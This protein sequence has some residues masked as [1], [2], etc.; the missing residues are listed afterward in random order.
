MGQR[1]PLKL[2][3]AS[4]APDK[5][6]KGTLAA[7]V[8]ATKLKKPKAIADNNDLNEIWDELVPELEASGLVIGADMVAIEAIVRHLA[9][10]R[11]ASDDIFE[12]ETTFLWDEAHGRHSKHPSEAVFRMESAALKDY[13]KDMG[14]TVVSRLRANAGE[15]G[16]TNDSNPFSPEGKQAN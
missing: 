12:D 5:A 6:V 16:A 11:Q 3:K 10:L 9:I 2:V 8:K 1:G 4:D 7:N 14:M 13:L 15:K